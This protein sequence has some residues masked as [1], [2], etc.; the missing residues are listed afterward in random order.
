MSA[1]KRAPAQVAAGRPAP[2]RSDN[3]PARV[4]KRRAETRARLMEAAMVVFA[5]HG[6]GQVSIEQICE[7]AGFSRGAFYSNFASIEQLFVAMYQ[8]HAALI[9][10]QIEEALTAEPATRSVRELIDRTVTALMVDRQWVMIKTDFLLHA[11]RTQGAAVLTDRHDMLRDILSAHWAATI[12]VDAL[13]AA[14]QTPD[15]LARAIITI[16]DGAMLQLLANPDQ[17]APRQW[18]QDLLVALL[19]QPAA[20]GVAGPR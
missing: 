12:P 15:G 16:H 18:L 7:A 9:A 14:L 20:H 2:V 19:V 13:P 10:G 1:T 6:F 11:A 17:Q 3:A 8:E 4:T 5:E